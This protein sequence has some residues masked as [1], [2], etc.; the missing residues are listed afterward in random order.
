[1]SGMRKLKLLALASMLAGF[2][3]AMPTKEEFAKVRDDVM[4]LTAGMDVADVLGL[5]AKAET[6]ASKYLLLCKDA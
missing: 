6:E 4:E 2:T 5:V 3:V 1:M